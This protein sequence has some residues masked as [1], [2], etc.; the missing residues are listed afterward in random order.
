MKELHATQYSPLLR[1]DI[2]GLLKNESS[3]LVAV[4]GIERCTCLIAE[5]LGWPSVTIL[6]STV[7]AMN[8]GAA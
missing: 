7:G 1:T 6:T 3:S 4:D 5:K 2:T 8:F